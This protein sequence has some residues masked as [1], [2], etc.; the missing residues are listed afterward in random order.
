M[1]IT[2][3]GFREVVLTNSICCSCAQSNTFSKGSNFFK[4]R[5]SLGYLDAFVDYIKELKYPSVQANLGGLRGKMLNLG[6]L[7]LIEF[8]LSEEE[9]GQLSVGCET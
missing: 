1:L 9:P 6:F 3:H 2:D 8:S 4:R 7:I 5:Y